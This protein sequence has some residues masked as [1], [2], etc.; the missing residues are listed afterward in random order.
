MRKKMEREE[1]RDT[2]QRPRLEEIHF[3]SPFH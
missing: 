2:Q 1:E 3:Y